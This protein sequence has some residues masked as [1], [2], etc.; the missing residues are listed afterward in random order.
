MLGLLFVLHAIL[1]PHLCCV[2]KDVGLLLALAN[3]TF[4]LGLAFQPYALELGEN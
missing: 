2:E 3:K 4:L 1:G